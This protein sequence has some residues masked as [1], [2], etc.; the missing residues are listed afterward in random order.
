MFTLTVWDDNSI[1][2]RPAAAWFP[3]DPIID[4]YNKIYYHGERILKYERQDENELNRPIP[5][6]HKLR[7]DGVLIIG[8]DQQ[9]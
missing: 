5:Y 6:V 3:T 8:W 9:M 2:L 7:L 1:E 4:N